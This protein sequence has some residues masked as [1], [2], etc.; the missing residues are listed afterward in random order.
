MRPEALASL[1]ISRG[2]V[3]APSVWCELF[4]EL[5]V[6]SLKAALGAWVRG[7]GSAGHIAMDGKRLRGSATATAPGAHL[8]AAFSNALGGVVG[9]LQVAPD[10]NEITAALDLL[11]ALPLEGS[12]V[13]G[14]AIFA[15]KEI[16][17]VIRD[18]GGRLLLHGQGQ[19]ACA[20]SR[21]RPGVWR[22][23]PPQ[24]QGCRLTAPAPRRSARSTAALRRARCKPQRALQPTSGLL[25]PAWPRCAASRAAAW[26]AARKAS[27][28][29]MPP[30]ACR[31]GGPMPPTCWRCRAATG[32]SRTACITCA[33]SPAGKTSAAPG[34]VQLRRCWPPCA[35]LS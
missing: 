10:S 27:K 19:P 31:L 23:F 32:A 20:Q 16:C 24:P 17:R 14:D 30:P 12:V 21:H 18:G 35:T 33:T 22:L 7:G 1:G 4:Q 8:L 2:R 29:C 13:T 3:P 6:A 15:Q 26:C 9:Q 34:R 25:G 11:R 28:P 5:D